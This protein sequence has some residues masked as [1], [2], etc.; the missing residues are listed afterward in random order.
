MGDIAKLHSKQLNQAVVLKPE[1]EMT[2]SQREADYTPMEKLS[3][4]QYI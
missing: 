4:N 3:G 1:G 2:A